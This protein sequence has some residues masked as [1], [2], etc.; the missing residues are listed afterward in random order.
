MNLDELKAYEKNPKKHSEQQIANLMES[1]EK[2]GFN[3]PVLVDKDNV[4]VAGHARL[5]AAKRLG[6]VEVRFDVAR[7]KK[8]EKFVPVVKVE[9]LSEQ[10]IKAF[11]IIDNKLNE[12]P[13][14]YDLL[15]MEALD[16]F[17]DGTIELLGFTE[18]EI[19]SL[20]QGEVEIPEVNVGESVEVPEEV[21]EMESKMKEK[22]YPLV[23]WFADLAEFEK[24]K[25]FFEEGGKVS[26]M[27]LLGL[28]Q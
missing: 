9:D 23:F 13:W 28:I 15:K 22:M 19:Q 14:D 3:F 16:L 11:R 21:R 6:W 26:S 20:G 24:A 2:F 10:E 7:A 12:S 18:K 4:V 1:V 17:K 27:K 8:G 25:A 5:E